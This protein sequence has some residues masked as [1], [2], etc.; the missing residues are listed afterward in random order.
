MMQLDE[1]T[2][3]ENRYVGRREPSLGVAYEALL[4]R[5]E[6]GFRDTE[7]CLRLMFLAWYSCS[8][9]GFL[10]GLPE[11][12]SGVF[13]Q[14]FVWLGGDSDSEPEVLLVIGWMAS[15]FP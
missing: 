1:I 13:H 15:S 9:P 2:Q 7:T 14:V 5:W 11:S 3:V 10:T 8:E 6:R 4:E 12:A